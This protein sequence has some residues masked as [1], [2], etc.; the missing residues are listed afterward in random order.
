MC[1]LFE[2][3]GGGCIAGSTV[4]SI[5]GAGIVVAVI[6]LIIILRKK[7]LDATVGMNICITC[8]IMFIRSKYERVIRSLGMY[9]YMMYLCMWQWCSSTA[10]LIHLGGTVEVRQLCSLFFIQFIFKF[11][12]MNSMHCSQQKWLSSPWIYL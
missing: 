1:I 4:G 11:S 12:V 6:V 7:K 10:S 8:I 9:E 5:T 2:G 3:C